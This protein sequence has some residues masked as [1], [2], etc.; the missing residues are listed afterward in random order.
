MN[1]VELCG[2]CLLEGEDPEKEWLKAKGDLCETLW[3]IHKRG[4]SMLCELKMFIIQLKQY[5]L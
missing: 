3:R 2:P 4:H 1:K 5:D